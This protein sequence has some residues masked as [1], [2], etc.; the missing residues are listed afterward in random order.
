M[1]ADGVASTTGVFEERFLANVREK[2]G[3]GAKLVLLAV[4]EIRAKRCRVLDSDTEEHIQ[5]EDTGA[6]P[7]EVEPY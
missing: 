7:V 1:R 3:A 5:G 2:L 6:D 4:P